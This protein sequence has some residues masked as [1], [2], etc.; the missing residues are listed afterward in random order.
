MPRRGE[1]IYKRKDGRWEGR[2]I[3]GR[4]DSGKAIYRS[5]YA[6]TY[7]EVRNKMKNMPPAADG[8]STDVTVYS[9]LN[10]YL[11]SRR[12]TLKIGTIKV[13][14]RYMNNYIKP[15]FDNIPFD[16]LTEEQLQTFVS[17][18]SKLAPSTVKSIFSFIR[19]AL[20]Q[21]HKQHRV[22]AVWY[23]VELPKSKRHQVDVFTLDEQK[24][25]EKSLT[26]DN[27]TNDIGILLCLYTGLR[28]GE[29]CGLKW[30][31]IDF[32][33]KQLTVSRTVQRIT[34]DGRSVV[35]ELPPKSETSH[36]AIPIPTF[37]L[38]LLHQLKRGSTSQYILNIRGQI[39]DPRAFQYHYKRVLERAGVRYLNPHTMRHTFSVRALELGF[40]VK[41]LSEV[42]GHSDAT[43]TLK[44]YAH[45][46][47]EHKRRSME[48][49]GELRI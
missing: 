23:G 6:H 25:I 20:K 8:S 29:V 13:Y 28:I 39:M 41:T 19:E 46:L 48:R 11:E 17:S 9:W 45:S 44:T 38:K 31:D 22:D 49:L 36:R 4:T 16:K 15:Q 40:D 5:V 1:N 7:T 42:L 35:L 14:E 12:S 27:T 47:D 2:I 30:N 34:I 43:I 24:L 33:S 21:A 3:A 10:K 32:I 18:L 37:L 26:I